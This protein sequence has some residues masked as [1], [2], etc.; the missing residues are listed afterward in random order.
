MGAFDGKVALIT[1]AASGIGRSTAVRLSAEG[2]HVIVA[3]IDEANGKEVADEVKGEFQRLD[4]GDPDSWTRVVTAV[5]EKSGGLDIAYLN[6]GVTLLTSGDD[7][8]G[9]GPDIAALSEADYRRIMRVNVDGV[10]YGARAVTPALEARG[11]G[12]IVATASVAG[13]FGFAADPIYTLTK[14]AV[15]GLVR[16]LAPSLEPRGITINAICPG[17]VATN[18]MG[19]GMAE[20]A[21]ESGV[22]IMQPAQ[23]ADAVVQA[24][25]SGKTGQAYVCLLGRD[26]E[27]YVFNP[28]PELGLG[29]NPDD[30]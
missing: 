8:T 17:G 15:I 26:H 5:G 28:I 1:G 19:P 16:A 4:V 9:T 14:H 27:E 10:V 2:A 25:L 12:A 30:R 13:L 20:A 18:I 24:I 22:P 7:L 23:I 29:L 11:G 3:D 6:A 21:R